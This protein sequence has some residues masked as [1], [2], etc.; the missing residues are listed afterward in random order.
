MPDAEERERI[1]EQFADRP[2]EGHIVERAYN[3]LENAVAYGDEARAEHNRE[4]LKSFG[5]QTAEARAAER[6]AQAR[7]DAAAARKAEK[8]AE[9]E[10][11]KRDDAKH[12]APQG[13]SA[14]PPAKQSTAAAHP[15]SK[16]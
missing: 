16:K 1:R 6:A 7:K 5:Y 4:E 11:G 2:G 9:A 15:A 12:E 14:T 10:S 13:R 3:E 8:E